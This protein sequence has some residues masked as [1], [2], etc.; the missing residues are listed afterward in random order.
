MCQMPHEK[1]T[2]LLVQLIVPE[3]T[4]VIYNFLQHPIFSIP[5]F[6]VLEFVTKIL[7]AFCD[8]FIQT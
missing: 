8:V 3:K 6:K 5:S 7:R 2:S 1:H 4:E